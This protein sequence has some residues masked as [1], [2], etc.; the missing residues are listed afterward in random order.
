MVGAF[1]LVE[2]GGGAWSAGLREGVRMKPL[3]I[4]IWA[5]TWTIFLL[6]GMVLITLLRIAAYIPF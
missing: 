6:T 4:A 5:I 2:R 1:L 3:Q